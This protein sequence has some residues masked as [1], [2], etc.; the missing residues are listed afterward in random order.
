[1]MSFGRV[2][3]YQAE[4]SRVEAVKAERATTIASL[5]QEIS[6]LWRELVVSPSDD[7]DQA[8]VTGCEG[9]GWGLNVIASLNGRKAE[10]LAE[11]E[12]REA[13]V[14]AL[15]EAIT[16]LWKRLMT[17]VELQTQFLDANSGI[18]DEVVAACEAYLAQLQAEFSSKL[19]SLIGHARSTL[20]GLWDEL[21]MGGEEARRADFPLAFLAQAGEG[22]MPVEGATAEFTDDLYQA[23]EDHIRTLTA[24]CEERRPILSDIG[25]REAM[26][27]DKAEYEAII[28][29]PGEWSARGHGRARAG[30]ALHVTPHHVPSPTP[31]PAARLLVKGSSAARLREEKLERR[32][33]KELPALSKKLRAVLEAWE[34]KQ[35]A[36]FLVDGARWLDRLDAEESSEAA[37]HAEDRAKRDA[38]RK[39]KAGIIAVEAPGL[40]AAALAAT[41]KAG[42][43]RPAVLNA[44]LAGSSKG[45]AAPGLGVTQALPKGMSKKSSSTPA[46][47]EGV[48]VGASKAA[49]APPAPAGLSN[50]AKSFANSKPAPATK[51]AV[52]PA[53]EG[54]A[55]VTP[56]EG[57]TGM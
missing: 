35:G 31:T 36:P 57:V 4:T 23:H 44:T 30:T 46:E 8:I 21:R 15:G 17:P 52:P 47:A 55:L 1:M 37:R 49:A 42:V 5:C 51:A 54:V 18:S 48:E 43:Y 56:V 9:C 3:Q 45:S 2:S 24:L 33:K 14:M 28:S 12:A 20:H 6:D 7:F 50:K 13:K 53:A 40:P 16:S 10:L 34:A 27:A 26:L 32:V 22:E 41:G 11:K 29:D 19:T 38:D 39:T 25:R